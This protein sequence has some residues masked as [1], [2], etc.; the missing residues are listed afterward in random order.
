MLAR[1]A[2]LALAGA[3]LAMPLAAAAT[4]VDV[5]LPEVAPVAPGQE[6]TVAG[7]LSYS[8]DAPSGNATNVSLALLTAP[9]WLTARIDPASVQAAANDSNGTTLVPVLLTVGVRPGTLAL[10]Q[11]TLQIQLHADKN[12]ALAAAQNTV[13]VVVRVAFVGA[14]QVAGP[15]DAV[16]AKPGEPVE[17]PLTISNTGNGPARVG[18]DPPTA[19]GVTAVP[20][21]PVVV[22]AGAQRV[23]NLSFLPQQAGRIPLTAHYTSTYA[24]DP[25][26]P[27]ASGD[28][29]F[30]LNVG[31][32]GLPAP[33]AM[34]PIALAALA[35]AWARRR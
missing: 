26:L 7:N 25:T 13:G 32:S 17:V 19:Q 31:G 34:V 14:L 21:A 28:V 12:G 22:E 18:F 5:V 27:G 1:R 35:L 23:V 15:S 3:L 4:K 9:D 24:F 20:P 11:H 10:Q 8:Y 29:T 2:A 30:S 6:R 16:P 33:D